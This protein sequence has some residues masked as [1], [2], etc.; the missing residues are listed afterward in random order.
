[1]AVAVG[2]EPQATGVVTAL[3]AEF[4]IPAAHEGPWRWARAT[5]PENALEFRWEISVKN[6]VGEYLFGFSFYK[7]PGSKE[8]G[9]NLSALLN[10]GQA[11]LWKIESDGGASVV[12]SANVSATAVEGRV[13]VRV[14]DPAFVRLLFGERPPVVKALSK[15]P[16]TSESH[17]ISIKYRK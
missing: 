11:S 12:E 9:G 3:L 8:G 17:E 14:S 6:R 1:M 15:T 5:T 13:V 16:E 4:S 10:A 7:F 2:A